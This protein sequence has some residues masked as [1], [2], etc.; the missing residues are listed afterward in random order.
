VFRESTCDPGNEM[1]Q[2]QDYSSKKMMIRNEISKRGRK[3]IN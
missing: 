1:G 2:S 3:K